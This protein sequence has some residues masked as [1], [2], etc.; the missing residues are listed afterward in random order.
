ME[1]PR[2]YE[3]ITEEIVKKGEVTIYS[4]EEDMRKLKE[5]NEY[6]RYMKVCRAK[7]MELKQIRDTHL[8]SNVIVIATLIFI[9]LLK[10]TVFLEKPLMCVLLFLGYI[11]VYLVFS[12]WKSKLDLISNVSASAV[13]LFIDWLF[14]FLL[15]MN[16][17][18]CVVYRYKKGCLGEEIGY[19]LFYDIRIDRI[20]NRNYVVEVKNS[21]VIDNSF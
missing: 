9:L 10:R 7:M 20:R 3:F 15:A 5:I 4:T 6:N 8:L 18:F 19:P 17:I 14:V 16:I 12:F 21:S 13:L 1:E 2:Q 11:V